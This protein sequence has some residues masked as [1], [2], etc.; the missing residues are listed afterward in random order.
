M[1]MESLPL[2]ENP[3][4]PD[5]VSVSLAYKM[6]VHTRTQGATSIVSSAKDCKRHILCDAV[7]NCYIN[8]ISF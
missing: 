7:K 4:V 6:H 3:H 2:H 8:F 1:A 5:S